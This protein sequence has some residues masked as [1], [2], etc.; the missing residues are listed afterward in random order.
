[1]PNKAPKKVVAL[2]PA[3]NEERRIGSTLSSLA[4][5][6]SITRVVVVDDGSTDLTA[7]RA[8][9]AGAEV[10][11]LKKNFGKG[12]AINE[13]LASLD[14]FE[15]LAILDADLGDSAAEA[16][17]LLEPVL[18]GKADMTIADFPRPDRKGGFGFVKRL[19]TWGIM[20]CSGL[21]VQEPLSGQ[22]AITY[23][24]MQ[25]VKKLDAGFGVE[26]GLTI[27]AAR[28]GFRIMEIPTTMSHAATGR[29]LAGFIHRGR[30]FYYVLKSILRRL[31]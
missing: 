27:D 4:A 3:F 6:K 23:A 24:V 21:S 29:N 20:K 8:E 18:A 15:V 13:A 17:K 11:K 19:A 28:K 10:M 7:A 5:I 31:R 16:E 26:V 14:D 30:Q 2:I 9:E 12:G 22:R 1:M 25:A